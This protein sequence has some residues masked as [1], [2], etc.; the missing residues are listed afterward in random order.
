MINWQ[1]EDYGETAEEWNAKFPRDMIPL[2]SEKGHGRYLE[3]PPNSGKRY[4]IPAVPVVS[5]AIKVVPGMHYGKDV[6]EVFYVNFVMPN[7]DELIKPLLYIERVGMSLKAK[8]V[9]CGASPT[10][11]RTA[12]MMVA[13]IATL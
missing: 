6:E 2:F 5:E 10:Q 7:G 11:I 8:P 4:F 1:W 12:L 13:N 3:S 9:I